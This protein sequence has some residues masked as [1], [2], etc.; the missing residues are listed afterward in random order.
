MGRMQEL[1]NVR[2]DGTYS[3]H[4]TL[5]HYSGETEE[6]QEKIEESLSK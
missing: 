3:N 5:Q 1:W 2:H 4:Q 6:N